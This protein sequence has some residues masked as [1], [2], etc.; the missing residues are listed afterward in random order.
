MLLFGTAAAASDYHFKTYDT[1]LQR[2]V[3]IEGV[4]YAGILHD[5]A[6][7]APLRELTTIDQATYNAFSESG[8][9]AYLINV[10]NF[11]TIGLIVNHFPIKTGVRDIDKPWS[12]EFVPLFGT[13]VSL[14][15]IEQT[16]LRKNFSEPR[17]H[18]AL[19][20][21]SKS[22]PT[23]SNKA[24]SGSKLDLQ[25]TE[26]AKKFLIDT[27]KNR[28]EG[29][30]LDLSQIFNWYGSDFKKT[31]GDYREFVIKTLGLQGKYSV[32]FLDYDWHLN[33]AMCQK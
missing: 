22:C 18:F 12:T 26:A 24:Y 6:L 15:Y 10:Y 23:L 28:V 8:K 33:N 1:F 19:V 30:T 17:I 25:L 9:I 11:F 7:V 27:T 2:Y 20:C 32:K 13:K 5:N 29:T 16:L 14:D 31:Y 4:D 3:C 21:A